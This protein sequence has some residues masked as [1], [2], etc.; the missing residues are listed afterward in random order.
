MCIGEQLGLRRPSLHRLCTHSL[1]GGDQEPLV[2][3]SS[4][5]PLSRS[6]REFFLHIGHFLQVAGRALGTRI[7]QVGSDEK[8]ALMIDY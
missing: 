3:T 7:L 8:S 5:Q 4:G 6:S 1:G 2:V